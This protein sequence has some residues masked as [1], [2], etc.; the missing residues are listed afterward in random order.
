MVSY[1]RACATHDSQ[2]TKDA[3]STKGLVSLVGTA[4]V[5]ESFRLSGT[6]D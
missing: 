3:I 6:T 1:L 5:P 2:L 4:R